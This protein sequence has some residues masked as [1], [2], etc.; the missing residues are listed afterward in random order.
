MV[1]SHGKTSKTIVCGTI[2]RKVPKTHAAYVDQFQSTL[3]AKMAQDHLTDPAQYLVPG[4]QQFLEQTKIPKVV[5][6]G[7]VYEWRK[8]AAEELGIW[9]LFDGL[10][11]SGQKTNRIREALRSRDLSPHQALIIGD[12]QNDVRS[13][14]EAGIFAIGLARNPKAAADFRAMPERERPHAIIHNDFT[15]WEAITSA[16]KI[17][18]WASRLEE[19]PVGSKQSAEGNK[20]GLWTTVVAACVYVAYNN[21]E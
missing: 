8:K 6:T 10:H 20:D 7:G 4:A 13:G 12:S 3:Y 16:L 21:G 18:V 19:D 17:P 9:R 1:Q 5:L 14:R 15:A 11:G 2:G